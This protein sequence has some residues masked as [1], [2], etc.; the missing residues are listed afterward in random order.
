MADF[1]FNISKGRINELFDR[2]DNND[3]AASALYLIP[4][5]VAAVTDA[6]LIDVDTF[7]LVISA[8]VTER[9]ANGWNRKTLDDTLIATQAPDDVNDRNERDIADQTW[10]PTLGSDTVTDLIL[11]YA[12]VVTPTDAQLVPISQHDFAIT[13]DGSLVTAVIAATGII[14][15]A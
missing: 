1:V 3:P 12:G 10:T 7:A 2:V 5:S 14:R 4:V 8:G 13:P 9:T 15:A 6:T 11:C